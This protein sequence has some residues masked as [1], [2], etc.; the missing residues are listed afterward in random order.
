MNAMT[1]FRLARDHRI[2]PSQFM[3]LLTCIED[4]PIRP[5]DISER[6]GH[7]PASI[8]GLLDAL[9]R[10]GWIIRQTNRKDRRSNLITPTEQAFEIFTNC[11]V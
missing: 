7:T 3:V 10:G 8:T 5:M 9:E 11:L 6:T 2:S 4:A 1:A